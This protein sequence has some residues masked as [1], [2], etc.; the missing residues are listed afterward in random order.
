V[1]S[2]VFDAPGSAAHCVIKPPAA[3]ITAKTTILIRI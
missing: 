3:A 1:Y 2:G